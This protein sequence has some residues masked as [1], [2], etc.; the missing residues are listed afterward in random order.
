MRDKGLLL[1][2]MLLA[3]G[4]DPHKDPFASGDASASEESGASMT[5]TA[6]ADT[7]TTA[8]ADT[9]S[10]DGNGPKLD[11]AIPDLDTDHPMPSCEVQD[12]MDAFGDCEMEAPPDSFDPD[13]QWTWDGG[14]VS[15]TP[16]VA[17]L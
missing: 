3:C 9:S 11:L 16:H 4:D 17:N 14:G 7:S 12:G 2:A 10:D 15:V 6:P 8:P 1:G 5:A 13:V